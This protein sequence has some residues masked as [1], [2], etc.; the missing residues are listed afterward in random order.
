MGS[1][2]RQ[3][4]EAGRGRRSI[5]G[6]PVVVVVA[7]AVVVKV[8]EVIG[9]VAAAPAGSGTCIDHVRIWL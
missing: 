8:V 3:I 7:M 9:M 1:T 4:V 6:G 2:E 5:R